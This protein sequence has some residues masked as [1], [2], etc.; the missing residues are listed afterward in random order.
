MKQ[1]DV[2]LILVISVI[3]AVF[4]LLLSNA[5]ISTPKNRKEKVEVVE[6][7]SSEF[8]QPNP[9]YFNKEAVNPT[10]LIEIGDTT[11]QNPIQ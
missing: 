6:A 8:S 7:I 11:N 5:L 10:K 9:K 3:S 1:K 2:M 4:S